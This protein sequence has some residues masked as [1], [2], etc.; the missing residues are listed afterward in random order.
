MSLDRIKRVKKLFCNV[1]EDA[2][3]EIT[4]GKLNKNGS[5]PGNTK[6]NADEFYQRQRMMG[7]PD[8]PAQL[9]NLDTGSTERTK[10]NHQ[11]A[12]D[13]MKLR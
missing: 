6:A 4:A 5:L 7:W 2:I 3:S 12:K 1:S 11:L 9:A 10:S 8:L 13:R